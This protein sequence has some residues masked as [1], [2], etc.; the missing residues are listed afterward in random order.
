MTSMAEQAKA[1]L[2]Q[3]NIPVE[4]LTHKVVTTRGSNRHLFRGSLAGK[5]VRYLGEVEGEL[6]VNLCAITSAERKYIGRTG[7]VDLLERA[8][9]NRKYRKRH[10][11]AASKR[12]QAAR[13]PAK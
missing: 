9:R 1:L 5:T 2:L 6:L 4:F 13:K 10:A 3:R 7:K 12:G 8:A 11:V